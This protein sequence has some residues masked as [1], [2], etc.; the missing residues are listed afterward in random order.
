[1]AATPSA[2][3]PAE[4]ARP[5]RPPRSAS[6]I[7]WAKRTGL[8]RL[9]L[10]GGPSRGATNVRNSSPYGP[11]RGL[12]ALRANTAACAQQRANRCR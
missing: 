6:P 10:A 1:M 9:E 3:R 11:S 2:G 12:T 4:V 8:G 5:P 7:A